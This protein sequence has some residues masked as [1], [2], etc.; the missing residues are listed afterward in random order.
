MRLLR[1]GL[2]STALKVRAGFAFCEWF[3]F[4]P[5][6]D[7]SKS[8]LFFLFVCPFGRFRTQATLS[9]PFLTSVLGKKAG[10][11]EFW[12][13]LQAPD[14]PLQQGESGGQ[15][16]ADV[17]LSPALS[18]NPGFVNSPQ[19]SPR[20]F[21]GLSLR[22]PLTLK[23]AYNTFN[24]ILK[25]FCVCHCGNSGKADRQKRRNLKLPTI[26]YPEINFFFFNFWCIFLPGNLKKYVC[27]FS[28]KNEAILYSNAVP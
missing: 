7:G 22:S 28:R 8:H 1:K 18:H 5:W 10:E 25:N 26:H 9:G 11:R 27:L 14:T 16:P 4:C 21:L 17:F 6:V 20:T 2:A 13:V 23:F 15:P 24:C 3:S 12:Q 19:L